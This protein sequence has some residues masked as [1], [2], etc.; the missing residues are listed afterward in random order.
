MNEGR[1]RERIYFV[2]NVMIDALSQFL[3]LAQKSNIG[4]KLG[5]SDG[6]GFP[7]L[8]RI[9]A[10]F[11]E[12]EGPKFEPMKSQPGF[13]RRSAEVH[14]ALA[15]S[16]PEPNSNAGALSECRACCLKV[17]IACWRPQAIGRVVRG[18]Q[19][20]LWPEMLHTL[21]AEKGLRIK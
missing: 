8:R 12:R 19:P 1:P 7:E 5:L 13:D 17:R 16:I 10:S 4:K 6:K 21:V 14:D 2:G 11:E 15:Q 18:Y 20:Y 3:P 9:R